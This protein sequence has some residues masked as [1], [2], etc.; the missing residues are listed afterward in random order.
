MQF[1][2]CS[3]QDGKYILRHQMMMMTM[4]TVVTL[5]VVSGLSHHV[6]RRADWQHSGDEG[7]T[8]RPAWPLDHIWGHWDWRTWYDAHVQYYVEPLKVKEH[9]SA[10]CCL[11]AVMLYVM[12]VH[13]FLVKNLLSG[14]DGIGAVGKRG[15]SDLPIDMHHVTPPPPFYKL[16]LDNRSILHLSVFSNQTQI[17]WG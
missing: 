16:G 9:M 17:G 15:G 3:V 12:S 7:H 2:F 13:F 1:P 10:L 5:Y 11:A 6:F 14:S 4:M 8:G